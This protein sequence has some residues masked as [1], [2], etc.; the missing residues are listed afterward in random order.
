MNLGTLLT[1]IDSKVYVATRSILMNVDVESLL[2]GQGAAADD[3][4]LSVAN[5]IVVEYGQ[6]GF[7]LVQTAGIFCAAIAIALF[8]IG[9]MLNNS[10]AQKRTEKKEGVPALAIGAIGLFAVGV[11]LTFAQS[12]GAKL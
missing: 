7:S 1:T 9:L 3:G 2:D 8:F 6:G 5:D 10:N 12:I 11:I 4:A